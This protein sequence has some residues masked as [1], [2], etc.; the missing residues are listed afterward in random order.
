MR[1]GSLCALLW[2]LPSWCDLKQIVLKARDIPGCLIAIV[3]KLSHQGQVIQMAWSFLQEVFDHLYR[4]CHHPEVDL[5]ATRCSFKTAQ[6]CVPSPRPQNVDTL[7]VFWED[8]GL[9]ALPLVSHLGK[10]DQQ[11]IRSPVQKG[12]SDYPGLTQIAM[13]LGP[14]GSIVSDTRLPPQPPNLVIQLRKQSPAQRSGQSQPSCVAPR[15]ATIKKQGFS[16]PVAGRIE[17]P[18]RHC[19]QSS[20]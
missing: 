20:L 17:A 3:G 10:N 9:Y 13:V 5:F 2:Q 12:D 8:L 15:A 18:Q 6:V 7:T 4:I 11:N 1:S 16:D 19:N 14:S